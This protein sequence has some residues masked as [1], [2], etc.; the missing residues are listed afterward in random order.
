MQRNVDGGGAAAGAVRA[1]RVTDN[2]LGVTLRHRLSSARMVSARTR[3]AMARSATH[4]NSAEASAPRRN[5]ALR[6]PHSSRIAHHDLL[7]NHQVQGQ[8]RG[9]TLPEMRHGESGAGSV[10][11]AHAPRVAALPLRAA[12]LRSNS[13]GGLLVLLGRIVELQIAD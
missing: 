1:P 12:P 6:V 8:S 10:A 7:N 11:D 9:E 2:S 5:R 13:V 3:L 4:S